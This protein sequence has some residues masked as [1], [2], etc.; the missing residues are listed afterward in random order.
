LNAQGLF[1]EQNAKT[2]KPAHPR[3]NIEKK[4]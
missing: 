3:H 2:K 1:N 4:K